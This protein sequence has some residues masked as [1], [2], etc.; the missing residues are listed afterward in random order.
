[1]NR[2]KRLIIVITAATLIIA[3][4]AVYAILKSSGTL[5]IL[6]FNHY[7][8]TKWSLG[9]RID[10][11]NT[12][13]GAVY[14]DTEHFEHF[15]DDRGQG[16]RQLSTGTKYYLGE[17]SGKLCVI[18]FSGNDEKCSVMS[19]HIGYSE[20]DAKNILFSEGFDA[21]SGRHNNYV[22]SNGAVTVE[23]EFLHG[24]V[25]GIAAFIELGE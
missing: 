15:S 23:L 14:Y 1:M 7:S 10:G 20:S 5:G 8:V 16:I 24:E 4:I 25:I 3:A 21:V 11:I 9:E 19:V 17:Y 18:G 12:L 2:K 22:A 13:G 6:Q